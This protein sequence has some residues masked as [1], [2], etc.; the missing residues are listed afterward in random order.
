M[1]GWPFQPFEDPAE[2]AARE[3]EYR[4]AEEQRVLRV[5][6]EAEERAMVD[7]TLPPETKATFE[8]LLAET[9]PNVRKRLERAR[10]YLNGASIPPRERIAYAADAVDLL[11]FLAKNQHS[12]MSTD[13]SFRRY[14]YRLEQHGETARTAPRP[15]G[16]DANDP[17][18]H[19]RIQEIEAQAAKMAR[20]RWRAA[21]TLVKTAFPDALQTFTPYDTLADQIQKQEMGT[22]DR[23]ESKAP[24]EH[25]S[26]YSELV[27]HQILRNTFAVELTE[28]C[29]VRC[30]F[31]AFDAAPGVRSAMPFEDVVW[32]LSRVNKHAFL[33]YATDPLDY[34]A[35]SSDGEHTYEDI[36]NIAI[37]LRGDTPFTATAVPKRSMD[38]FTNIVDRLDRISVSHMNE[39]LLEKNG[40][41]ERTPGGT[42]LPVDPNV[43]LRFWAGITKSTYIPEIYYFDREKRD[44][45]GFYN[46]GRQRRTRPHADGHA[47]GNAV[48]DSIACRDGVVIS[49]KGIKNSLRMMTTDAFP[50]GIAEASVTNDTLQNGAKNIDEIAR[51]L[52]D[53]APVLINELLPHVV[54]AHAVRTDRNINPTT[55]KLKTTLPSKIAFKAFRMLDD[56]QI[57]IEGTC[58]FD[59]VTGAMQSIILAQT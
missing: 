21:E 31:C 56:A 29:S 47:G 26:R 4:R 35:P 55:R 24:P 43:A 42:I 17:E 37:I 58:N 46:S 53:G 13:Y 30:T 34:R 14:L 7:A 59:R 54:V 50:N 5:K 33:Y 48:D 25:L 20:I 11:H 49:P 39:Q 3:Q 2:R 57:M 41:I 40:I 8:E 15:T 16:S 6:A 22:V 36:L 9:P 45:N 10:D 44:Q 1:L 27:R 52:Q 38:V 32:L 23:M 18:I 28:G 51:K 19:K 12:A